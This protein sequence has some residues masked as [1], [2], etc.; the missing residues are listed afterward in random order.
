[1]VKFL[2]FSIATFQQHHF[3]L[4]LVPMTVRNPNVVPIRLCLA[5]RS[6]PSTQRNS[7]FKAISYKTFYSNSHSSRVVRSRSRH[8]A[9]EAS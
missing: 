3:L 2:F 9:N 1:M 7:I 8:D 5:N 6:S 4:L